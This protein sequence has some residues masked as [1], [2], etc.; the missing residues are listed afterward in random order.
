MKKG[1]LT[2]RD[3]E[4]ENGGPSPADALAPAP[5]IAEDPIPPRLE[6]HIE[7]LVLRGF[8]AGD[9]FGIGDS[10]ERELAR[11]IAQQGLSAATA[12]SQSIERLDGGAFNVAKGAKPQ[13]IGSQIAQKVYGQIARSRDVSSPHR[14]R[15]GGIGE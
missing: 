3:T 9:R 15:R 13:S 5:T 6:I 2:M 7:E 11:L 4:R 1:R 8:A 14:F 10:L 12:R